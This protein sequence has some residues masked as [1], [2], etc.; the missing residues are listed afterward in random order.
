MKLFYT[1]FLLTCISASSLLANNT[2][3]QSHDD[4]TFSLNKDV[5][6]SLQNNNEYF[7]FKEN[8]TIEENDFTFLLERSKFTDKKTIFKT[9]HNTEF[10][11]APGLYIKGEIPG[12]K[13]SILTISI[14]GENVFGFI[15]IDNDAYVLHDLK[16]SNY[17]FTKVDKTKNPTENF[18]QNDLLEENILFEQE[19]TKLYEEYGALKKN[20]QPKDQKMSSLRTVKVAL[21]CDNELLD[22]MGGDSLNVAQYAL[23]L[24][25]SVHAIYERD[26]NVHIAVP[27]LNVWTETDPYPGST[28]TLLLNQFRSYWVAHDPYT[29]RS[30]ASLLSGNIGRGGLAWVGKL[31]SDFFGYSFMSLYSNY[32]YPSLDYY[33]DLHVTTHE[34]G[35][36]IGLVHTHSCTWEPPID[37][38]AAA[39]N[40]DCFSQT[41]PTAGTIMSYCHSIA[42][43]SV[44]L[45]FHDRC[46]PIITASVEM[47]LCT[48]M[49]STPTLM[50]PESVI[51]CSNTAIEIG[52]EASG[53]TPPYTYE[54][55]QGIN[56]VTHD[57]NFTDV[58]PPS[59][60]EYVLR[61]RDANNFEVFANTIVEV[62]PAPDPNIIGTKEVCENQVNSFYT[63]FANDLVYQWDVDGAINTYPDTSNY[64]ELLWE[65][66]GQKVIKVVVKQRN[67]VCIDSVS[68]KILVKE[69]G[70]QEIEGNSTLCQFTDGNFTTP[71][72]DDLIYFWRVINGQKVN[73][74]SNLCRARF[75]TLGTAIIRLIAENKITGCIDSTDFEVDVKPQP[76]AIIEADSLVCEH[77]E[78]TITTP[79][80]EDFEVHNIWDISNGEILEQN[81][82]TLTL[83]TGKNGILIVNL[84][85]Y[86]SDYTCSDSTSMYISVLKPE[87]PEIL[88]INDDLCIDELVE[89][90]TKPLED[91]NFYWSAGAS[92][93]HYQ[94]NER[95]G[96][97]FLESG[98]HEIRLIVE[99]KESG[100]TDTSYVSVNVLNGPKVPD[101]EGD[102]EVCKG[103]EYQYKTDFNNDVKYRWFVHGGVILGKDN[104]FIVDV[105]WEHDYPELLLEVTNPNTGCKSF[106]TFKIN[107]FEKPD[108]NVSGVFYICDF[109]MQYD[110]T[111]KTVTGYSFDI[112]VTGGNIVS[113]NN[114]KLTVEWKE[115]V[116]FHSINLSIEDN[117]NGCDYNYDYVISTNANEIYHIAGEESLC[118]NKNYTY[119]MNNTDHITSIE[120]YFNNLKI[121][122]SDTQ[123]LSITEPG[124]LKA[125]LLFDNNCSASIEK[126]LIL[127]PNSGKIDIVGPNKSCLE[128]REVY[129]IVRKPEKFNFAVEIEGGYLYSEHGDQLEVVWTDIAGGKLTVSSDFSDDNCPTSTSLEVK[130]KSDP[131]L[132][133]D[134][135]ES[136]C[137]NDTVWLSTGNINYN[138]LWKAEKGIIKNPKQHNTFVYWTSPGIDNITLIKSSKDDKYQDSL[139][140]QVEVFDLPSVPTIEIVNG[141]TAKA[142][143]CDMSCTIQ[144]YFEGIPISDANN[145]ILIMTE[146]GN[147]T[148]EH[149]SENGCSAVSQPYFYKNTGVFEEDSEIEL[150]IL[151][152]PNTGTFLLK[153]TE[154]IRNV[155]IYNTLGSLI[156][157]S[158]LDSPQM[159]FKILDA[160]LVSGMYYISINNGEY[161]KTFIVEK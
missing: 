155:E 48:P 116:D 26:V 125:N 136:L 146:E 127:N 13:N 60:T 31:C 147:Y 118:Y 24:W 106:E 51:T 73:A 139:T 18:C 56:I 128:C 22:L 58:N 142:S 55:V 153:S 123:I 152:N 16:N 157:S 131:V 78:I 71:L 9:N 84:M 81:D 54:W 90:F 99:H 57:S 28:A 120:W 19:L 25:A 36:N 85:S 2:I 111:I 69:F 133:F 149:I 12:V 129:E 86:N 50:L 141:N 80:P 124:T 77:S 148:V 109:D 3:F 160:K 112:S 82:S 17:R 135:E 10:T 92:H 11:V 156:Y 61:A 95:C 65:E 87:A 74:G 154:L 108:F 151:P 44:N 113:Q 101:V 145:Q 103:K 117:T 97:S 114:N 23:G 8:I 5:I 43:G 93:I 91:Y 42:G 37:S 4:N 41:V 159:E 137:Q 88:G 62:T 39:E 52:G 53:G 14:I 76:Q 30:V 21:E 20:S 35:H 33:W 115:E 46:K 29:D 75:D 1:L 49:L 79:I 130:I 104:N 140:N 143:A 27:Y 6:T 94:E 126:E 32:N 150:T 70:L 107:Y 63:A 38:C 72:D 67:G 40:G 89:V 105:M 96:I 122:N 98:T 45:H 102:F 119:K 132:D 138:V 100:C 59:T 34:L 144:W 64:V 47:A 68:K 66:P 158:D 121:G 15:E 161:K 7:S 110:Y 134:I 83:I